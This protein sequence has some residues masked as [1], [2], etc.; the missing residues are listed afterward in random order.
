MSVSKVKNP[1]K[2]VDTSL[3]FD[4][5]YTTSIINQTNTFL[6]IKSALTI[7]TL[8]MNFL[9]VS[10]LGRSQVL[11]SRAS[12][13]KFSLAKHYGINKNGD[14]RKTCKSICLKSK[15]TSFP[16]DGKLT[17]LVMN[18]MKSKIVIENVNIIKTIFTFYDMSF[19]IILVE[20]NLQTSQY[21]RLCDCTSSGRLKCTQSLGDVSC[22]RPRCTTCQ[23]S[24][25][26]PHGCFLINAEFYQL[27]NKSTFFKIKEFALPFKERF[28]M[29]LLLLLTT[30]KAPITVD[31]FT[32]F[33]H[34]LFTGVEPLVTCSCTNKHYCWHCT[35][36]DNVLYPHCKTVKYCPTTRR[37]PPYKDR[38]AMV[39]QIFLQN[40]V[41][42]SCCLIGVLHDIK[43]RLPSILTNLSNRYYICQLR[44]PYFN[45]RPKEYV[46]MNKSMFFLE[47]MEENELFFGS[48]KYLVR[49]TKDSL[50]GHSICS[51][52]NGP[53]TQNAIV[54]NKQVVS[55]IPMPYK[56]FSN[57]NNT[58]F[59][60]I[61]HYPPSFPIY[62][63]TPDFPGDWKVP[64]KGK[65][66]H[67]DHYYQITY[68]LEHPRGFIGSNVFNFE[69]EISQKRYFELLK[70]LKLN[71][72]LPI[73][74][75]MIQPNSV[76]AKRKLTRSKFMAKRNFTSTPIRKT[77]TFVKKQHKSLSDS[78]F[79]E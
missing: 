40:T 20:S 7:Q 23:F 65:I 63:N 57:Y 59:Q 18:D 56:L 31:K 33:I 11:I 29:Y 27:K 39:P 17:I 43:V 74:F 5:F 2:L 35:N 67:K 10:T 70:V 19:D 51:Y 28:I 45:I 48:L 36:T 12:N 76:F 44:A 3:V 79:F 41:P 14:I 9:Q 1:F 16:G 49:K 60:T 37:H 42:F 24:G 8:L 55:H 47:C 6:I 46:H 4:Q 50:T 52:G 22:H 78:G 64:G 53:T 71:R 15:K 25:H 13:L 68:K 72:N 69:D 26:P 32:L 58:K 30:P 77:S 75:K 73:S 38:E 34:H 66:K 61:I 21:K 62:Y 54:P